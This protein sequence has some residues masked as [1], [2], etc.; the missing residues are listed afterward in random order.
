MQLL[1]QLH[2]ALTLHHIRIWEATMLHIDR[3]FWRYRTVLGA[4]FLVVAACASHAQQSSTYG[5]VTIPAGSTGLVVTRSIDAGGADDSSTIIE[6]CVGFINAEQPDITFILEGAAS[7]IRFDVRSGSDTTLLVRRPNGEIY[8]DDDTNGLNPAV[9]I[10]K[11]G[12]GAYDVWIGVVEPVFAAAEIDVTLGGAAALAPARP[13]AAAPSANQR[14]EFDA[15]PDTPAGTIAV[16]LADFV[17]EIR[18]A[19]SQELGQEIG[20]TTSGPITLREEAAG[21]YFEARGLNVALDG[22]IL[23]LGDVRVGL[24]DPSASI[25]YWTLEDLE[26]IAFIEGGERAGAIKL[27]LS[28]MAGRYDRDAGTHIGYDFDLRDIAFEEPTGARLME[29]G[30]ARLAMDL[31]RE[32]SGRFGGPILF[33]FRDIVINDPETN[34]SIGR[35]GFESRLRSVDLAALSAINLD[36]FA[37][38]DQAAAAGLDAL[39][40]ILGSGSG[41]NDTE[42]FIG[43]VRTKLPDGSDF[44]LGSLTFEIGYGTE[45]DLS[46]LRLGGTVEELDIDDPQIPQALRQ[47]SAGFRIALEGLPLLAMAN[48]VSGLDP[49]DEAQQAQMAQALLGALM[50]SVPSLR[51]DAFDITTDDVGVTSRGRLEMSPQ[52]TP[53]GRFDVVVRGL[54]D[55]I[56]D[57]QS[58]SGGAILNEQTLPLLGFARSIGVEDAAYPGSLVFKIEVTPDMKVLVNG[59]D[60]SQM[61]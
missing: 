60:L 41:D 8:C 3:P 39:T 53:S 43:G 34:V 22:A 2:F 12:A 7:S 50:Q 1:T 16:Q 38:S 23:G 42:L 29:L 25:L 40:R 33:E 9:Q 51:L 48:A 21:F 59:L 13:L 58:G 19:A 31:A 15:P 36:S 6:G 5:D 10:A 11:A 26:E 57:V 28:R 46:E 54:P 17:E 20:I 49:L 55:L 35:I 32:A 18:V 56:A 61:E 14:L 30:R 44:R 27:G 37:G 52:M 47:G 45:G 24:S 4:S